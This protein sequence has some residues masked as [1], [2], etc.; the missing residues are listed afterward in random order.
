MGLGSERIAKRQHYWAHLD[1]KLAGSGS[2][3]RSSATAEQTY[4]ILTRD[5][6]QL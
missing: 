4:T 1:I 2:L 6:V 5:T 3:H